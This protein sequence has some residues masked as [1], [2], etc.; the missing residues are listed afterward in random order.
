MCQRGIRH[1]VTVLPCA[2]VAGPR[3]SAR[4]PQ[5]GR[6]AAATGAPVPV[7]VGLPAVQIVLEHVSHLGVEEAV[8]EGDNEALRGKIDKFRV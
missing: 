7:P 8:G 3:V 5:S 2:G 6:P 4:S 1:F